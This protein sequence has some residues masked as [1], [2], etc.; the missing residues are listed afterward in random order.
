MADEMVERV[1]RVIAVAG[2][3]TVVR[4]RVTALGQVTADGGLINA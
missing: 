2:Q 4:V 1:D 3:V